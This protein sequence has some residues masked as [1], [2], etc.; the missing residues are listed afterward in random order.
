MAVKEETFSSK[1]KR[2]VLRFRNKGNPN[3]SRRIS[4]GSGVADYFPYPVAR[5]DVVEFIRISMIPYVLQEPGFPTGW[6]KNPFS[7]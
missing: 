7:F 1:E 4:L 2:K 6:R 5:N 3:P